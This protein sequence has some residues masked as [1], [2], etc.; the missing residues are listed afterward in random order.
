[1]AA[2]ILI[3]TYLSM[4][5]TFYI[6]QQG[7]TENNFYNPILDVL[8]NMYKEQ[9]Y[10]SINSYIKEKN[11]NISYEKE[12]SFIIINLNKN[13]K[14]NTPIL[15]NILGKNYKISTSKAIYE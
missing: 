1:M 5:N 14:I 8:S 11:I 10:N 3:P 12:D 7:P 9:D 13:I 4:Q 2:V 6:D 15:N